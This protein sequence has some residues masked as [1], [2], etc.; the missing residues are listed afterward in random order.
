[1]GIAACGGGS[2]APRDAGVD[3][4]AV[5]TGTRL[6][7]GDV[8]VAGITSDGWVAVHDW[9]RGALAVPVAGG[10]PRLIDG[11]A[12][13]AY[14][15]GETI[16][17]YK[18]WDFATGIGDI[19]VWTAAHGEQPLAVASEGV[20]AYSDD[21]SRLL[22]TRDTSSD[23]TNTTVILSGVD[24][25]PATVVGD[26]ARTPSCYPRAQYGAGMFVVARC[27]PLSTTIE[28]SAVDAKTGAMTLLATDVQTSFAIVG[29]AVAAIRSDGDAVLLPLDGPPRTLANDAD[30]VVATP[31]GAL[32][33]R[34]RG[35]I[36]RVS[37]DGS[38][39]VTLVAGGAATIRDV[40]PDGA[41]L[42]YRTTIGPRHGYG[43][44]LATS[45]R[46]PWPPVTLS[47]IPNA[48]TFGS[49]FTSDSSRV[50]YITDAD[51]LYT[52]TL[53]ARRRSGEGQATTLGT[54]VWSAS[55][56]ASTRVVF[57]SDDSP[58]PE[59]RGRGVL[60]AADTASTGAPTV[61]ATAVGN[62]FAL[63]PREDA[64]V[65]SVNDGTERAGIYVAP[66]PG[67][68][69]RPL[70]GGAPDGGGSVDAASDVAAS[71]G[72]VADAPQE[73]VPEAGVD[74]DAAPSADGM[75]AG[76]DSDAAASDDADAQ[77]P[78]GADSDA[79]D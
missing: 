79:G 5:S 9:K 36:S 22:A 16:L 37:L 73:S 45:A 53:H 3:L 67:G 49:A 54:G 47:Q 26:A 30:A 74:A 32:L 52:G 10:E 39:T 21:G 18:N 51:D 15:V 33:V 77:A 13:S 14:A 68:V 40:S 1:M 24:G 20:L 25:A 61:L 57:L 38:P 78:D 44:L 6:V 41:W 46:S 65:Y 75:D 62:A 70:D 71:D 58:I 76:V 56:Y 60:R 50:L 63:T 59:G 8:D 72:G 23:G 19:S 17:A 29:G 55:A 64:V 31:D 27:E 42:L 12:D 66:L 34:A 4:G 28:L 11:A 43:D 69:P 48:T 35:A 7:A 2:G